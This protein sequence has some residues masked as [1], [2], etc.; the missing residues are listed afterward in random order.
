MLIG[1]IAI[2]WSHLEFMV[3]QTICGLR[4]LS[5]DEIHLWRG[6]DIAP[7]LETLK[8]EAARLDPSDRDKML[9]IAERI[10][11]VKTE[12]NTLSHGVCA[13]RDAQGNEPT[14]VRFRRNAVS[15]PITTEWLDRTLDE[16]AELA[17]KLCGFLEARR[18]FPSE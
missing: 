5:E 12:R 4:G 1:L 15:T 16:I 10:N 17:A 13:Y 8:E 2:H 14:F 7:K 18:L 11:V 6:K 9:A 3:A